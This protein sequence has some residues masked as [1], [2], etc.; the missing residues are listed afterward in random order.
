MI[1]R[2]AER[3]ST[4]RDE[5]LE[6]ARAVM[7]RDTEQIT[8]TG[9]TAL[10]DTGET[11]PLAAVLLHGLTNHPGQFIEFAPQ[12]HARG[13]NVFVPRMPYH[14]YADR[15]TDAIASLTAEELVAAAYEAVDIAS[16]LGQRVAVM[17]ISMGGLLAAYL[18]QYRCGIS[19]SVPVAPDFGLLRLPR[20]ATT[21][22]AAVA[23]ALPNIFLWWDPRI[24][25]AQRPKTAYPRFS[26]H[27]LMQT[28][29]IGNDV[30]AQA[31]RTPSKARR[32]AVV[33]NAADPAVNNAMTQAVVDRWKSQ[34][35]QGIESTTYTDL[36]RNH[37]IIDPDNPLARTDVVYPRLLDIL[38]KL[39]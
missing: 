39:P 24:K 25:Q 3:P 15:M 4:T 18:A 11:T 6:R 14:G 7:A 35:A 29:R 22:L 1:R 23:L 28:V 33:N 12:L 17:G 37:D 31:A 19:H 34:R 20:T 16:G 10:L 30:H 21:A 2:P 38:S 5:A 32:I 36:P 26:T 9:R 8:P 27:A 13:V